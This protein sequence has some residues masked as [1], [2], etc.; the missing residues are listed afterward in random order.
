VRVI[1]EAD[2]GSRGNPGTAGYGAVVLDA[3]T[4]ELLAERMGALGIAT[5]N[6]A[7]YQGLIAGL[8]AAAEL[9]ADEV[10]ARM[11]SKLVVEQMSGRWQIKHP[12]L[13]PLA[14]QAANL[15]RRFKSVKFTWIPRERN[16]RAD[17]LANR[18]MDGK[19]APEEP[20]PAAPP[21]TVAGAE[22]PGRA[23]ARAA[24]AAA[25]S[26]RTEVTAPVAPAV[27]SWMPPTAP[28]TRL[29]LV[30]HGETEYTA[31]KLYSGRGD[32]AL[33]SRG[34]A[35][36]R[37]AAE[38]VGPV[39]AVVTSP[40]SRCSRTAELIAEAAGGVP[41]RVEPDLVECDFGAWEG[42]SF[43]QVQEGWPDQMRAWLASPAVAPPDGESF[44]E[45]ALRV[46]R[47]VERLRA[48]YPGERVAVVSHVSP[49]K[50][51]L[52]DALAAGPAFLH[53]CYLEPA[54]VSTVDYWQDGGIA[55][56]SVNETA[57]LRGIT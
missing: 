6:V 16:K 27:S 38:R 12:G 14:A 33:T 39:A 46:N 53:R 37:A 22:S 18:A 11:D 34:L 3:E 24:A 52:R 44:D 40:L 54:G 32:A 45:V 15:V 20:A 13:R 42:L 35:Q 47:A 25:A 21:R 4:G 28:A 7:E 23:A 10:E 8:T 1:V 56:R 19:S 5:N 29:I 48:E 50:L 43:A 36:A 41:V 55:V 31:R 51:I 9:G 49:I 26:T 57:H 2:G 17:A 30:R